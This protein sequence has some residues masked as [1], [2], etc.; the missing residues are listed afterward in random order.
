MTDLLK[1]LD[2]FLPRHL[3]PRDQEL[4]PMLEAVGFESLDAL[5]T[6]TVPDAIRM[7]GELRGPCG[8]ALSESEALAV[9][10]AKVRA[11]QPY[12]SYI[13]MGYY[14]CIVP[15]VIQ[16]NVL[17]NPGWYTQYT[18]YQ[19]E[20]SQGRLQALLNYQTMVAELTGLEVANASL[21]DEGTAAAEAM[22]LCMRSAKRRQGRRFLVDENLNPQTIEVVETRARPLEID[23]EIG[24]PADFRCDDTVFGILLAY[25]DTHSTVRDLEAVTAS[26]HEAGALVAVVT[27][28]LSLCL[29]KPPGEWGADVAVGSSQRFGVPMGFG[30]PHAAFFATREDYKRRVPGRIIGVSQDSNGK[31]ALRMALQTREQH[32]RRDRATSNIC[33][34][35]VLL[36]I[37]AGMYAVYHGA[38]G[39]KAIAARVHGLCQGLAK[40]LS[41]LG[42]TVDAENR[43][44]SLI[45]DAGAKAQDLESA[46]DA[47]QINLRPLGDGRFGI[48]LDE[49]VTES[50]LTDLLR[51]FGGSTQDLHEGLAAASTGLPE[52]LR[53]SSPP[54]SHGVFDRYHAEHEM[55]RYLTMLQSRD[56][57][58]TGSMIPLGSCTMKLNATAEMLPVTWPELGG[59]HPFA[60]ARQTRGYESMITDLEAM[61]GEI[62]G[63]AAVSLQ[64]NAGSQG[65]YAGMLA[66]AAYHEARG[67][68]Q[69]KV[70]LIPSSAH[71]TNPASAVLAG[72]DIAVVACD[73]LG[74]VDLDDLRNQA[75][76]HAETLAAIMVTYP[77]T[78]GVFE[79]GIVELCQIV[80][81]H[82]GQVYMDGANMNAQVGLCRPGDF[83]VD[84][85]HL[86]LHKTFAIP[87]GGGG[88]GI[89]PIA[90]AEHLAPYLPGHSVRPVPGADT[91]GA[92]SAAPWGSAGVLCI[93][94]MYMKMLGSEGMKRSTEVAILN[95]NYLKSKLQAHYPVL[96]SG[97]QGT[98]AHEFIL[99]LRPLK[100]AC[101]VEVADLAKRLM[102]YGFHA[103]TMAFPVPGTLMI[104]PTES[105][106]LQELDRLVEA[107]I[108]IR[109]EI[110]EIERGEVSHEDSLLAR[111]PH[112]AEVFCAEDWD[113]PYSRERAAFPSA[114]TRAYKFWPAVGRID[115]A[116]GDRNLICTCPPLDSY[117][118]A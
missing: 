16:R 31:P 39:L 8:P 106:S 95:A 86:N 97:P 103:P 12:R 62:T 43:F 42:W 41:N 76:K 89:G 6:A 27:D 71:G 110:A 104:E 28:L 10:K 80:H 53:R 74:N 58:L 63:M 107:L 93:S 22:T 114:H 72:L 82:G 117:V 5:M 75:S 9:L 79:E 1:P 92:V 14:P 4:A 70:C 77:S 78:H 111:A 87:H 48:S 101:G 54:V 73:D 60:P 116:F 49:A 52:P 88:P 85:M 108:S 29:L 11:N 55:L 3:G 64:P 36:A 15:P 69:R 7:E 40:A 68:G 2:A 91:V 84:V 50:E 23:L 44:D 96:Y 26:A 30:G 25:P 18:P 56:L 65:E 17:E 34:S 46:L 32:I 67:Q 24:N 19:A 45:V 113:R 83:G 100:K 105:E 115:E 61:L 20:I 35:Q 57:S 94:W 102:D 51:C 118:A 38:D 33:T 90:V 47:A 98:V 112:S 59:I 81:E 37:M 99:D 13:G 21:L 66:I 109:E